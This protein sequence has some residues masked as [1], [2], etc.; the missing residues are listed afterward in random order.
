MRQSCSSVPASYAR[1][2]IHVRLGAETANAYDGP[3]VIASQVR[4]LHKAARTWSWTT[5]S[6]C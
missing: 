3:T 6:R 2:R 5:T 4:S 1:R